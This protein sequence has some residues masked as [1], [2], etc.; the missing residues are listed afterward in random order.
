MCLVCVCVSEFA[1]LRSSNPSQNR[2][3]GGGEW[4][5]SIF[6]ETSP[7]YRI[8]ITSDDLLSF[9]LPLIQFHL[10]LSFFFYSSSLAPVPLHLLFLCLSSFLRSFLSFSRVSSAVP[11]SPRPSPT[12][13]SLCHAGE[14]YIVVSLVALTLSQLD[15]TTWTTHILPS[16]MSLPRI[17]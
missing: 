16:F 12:L 15:Q 10:L 5:G 4:P 6:H 11:L 1:R 17:N 3:T 14:W 9:L 7:P 13:V 8:S 2:I